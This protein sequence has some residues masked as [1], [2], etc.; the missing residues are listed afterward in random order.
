[1]SLRTVLKEM[2]WNEYEVRAYETLLRSGAVKALDLASKAD[3]PA[4]RIHTILKVL[5][6][7]GAARQAGG[8]GSAWVALSP[9]DL[10]DGHAQ[11]V[12]QR[13]ED[14]VDEALELFERA[15]SARDAQSPK[16]WVAHGEEE[17][18][19]QFRRLVDG[20]EESIYLMT[21]TNTLRK[22]LRKRL[23]EACARGV[24]V[25][26]VATPA[27]EPMLRDLA[28]KGAA[29]YIAESV[30]FFL[31]AVDKKVGGVSFEGPDCAAYCRNE[32]HA[33]MLEQ[34]HAAVRANASKVEVAVLDA[35]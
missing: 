30:P 9:K 14:A 19:E 15:Q 11:A 22:A 32:A 2:R 18:V 26:A 27:D 20:A 6:E 5:K 23:Q 7:R 17:I 8:H 21:P 13:S 28:A 3:I 16:L 24:A 34:Q 10:L 31:V 25:E 29:C 1:M 33:D 35:P 12:R 4:G